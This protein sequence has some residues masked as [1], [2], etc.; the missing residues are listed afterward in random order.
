LSPVERIKVKPIIPGN[1][2]G[3]ALV[4]DKYISFFGEIDPETGCLREDP[5]ICL[6]GKVFIFKGS[7]GSTVGP[8]ILYA[9][10]K[11]DNHPICIIAEEVEPLLIAG[12]VLSEIPLYLINS[13]NVLV[14]EL[15][16]KTVEVRVE[17]NEHYLCS[18]E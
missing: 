2:R 11:H 9:L 5:G 13:F 8:Y 3:V 12:C 14:D 10:R 16:G 18:L 1:C 15:N 6:S 7:R 4:L 17:G